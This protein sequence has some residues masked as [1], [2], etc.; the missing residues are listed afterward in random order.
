MGRTV[1]ARPTPTGSRLP[2]SRVLVATSHQHGGPRGS[3]TVERPRGGTK[4]ARSR[5]VVEC[6]DGSGVGTC[7]LRCTAVELA[8]GIDRVPR[9]IAVGDHDT[10][11][12]IDAEK[13]VCGSARVG[14][15]WVSR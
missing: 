9:S 4:F 14:Y 7:S 1:G 15:A 12:L 10:R 13:A 8:V 2:R 3:R 6:E 11:E 5:M